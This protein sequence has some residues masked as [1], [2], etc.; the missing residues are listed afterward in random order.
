MVRTVA[1]M[2][3]GQKNRRH[4]RGTGVLRVTENKEVHFGVVK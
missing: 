3:R 4:C 2:Q 1:L